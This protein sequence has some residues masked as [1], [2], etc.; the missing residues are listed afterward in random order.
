MPDDYAVCEEY[1]VQD[2]K[3]RHGV[4]SLLP[5]EFPHANHPEVSS[6]ISLAKR[7]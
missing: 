4:D 2:A 1:G 7:K 6:W 5:S 3:N